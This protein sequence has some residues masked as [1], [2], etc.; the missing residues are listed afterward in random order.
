MRVYTDAMEH[1]EQKKLMTLDTPI[2]DPNLTNEQFFLGQDAGNRF[3]YKIVSFCRYEEEAFKR[4]VYE[5]F[6]HKKVSQLKCPQLHQLFEEYVIESGIDKEA[7]DKCCV[8]VAEHGMATLHEI[9]TYRKQANWNWTESEFMGLMNNMI[10][11]VA[12]LHSNKIV[13]R[14]IRPHNILYS[15]YKNSYV[16]TGFRLSKV[17][18]RKQNET[19]T[20]V[21]VPYYANP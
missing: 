20:I 16:L 10:Q 1:A 6:M 5:L 13:H 14:D 9:V 21:G 19:H 2:S 7:N 17:L 12:A 4:I 18:T 8:T 11:A 3:L 15:G